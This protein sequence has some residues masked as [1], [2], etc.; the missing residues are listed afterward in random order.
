MLDPEARKGIQP[1]CEMIRMDE[2]NE[3]V[4]RN[5]RAEVCN[6]FVIDMASQADAEG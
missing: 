2:I 5:V 3:A 6:R 4:E 1:D